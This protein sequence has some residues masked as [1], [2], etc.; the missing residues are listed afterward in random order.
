MRDDFTPGLTFCCFIECFVGHDFGIFYSYGV[1]E[2]S[3]MESVDGVV[4]GF[5]GRPDFRVVEEYAFDK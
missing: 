3:T 2:K 5:V 4:D 1:T